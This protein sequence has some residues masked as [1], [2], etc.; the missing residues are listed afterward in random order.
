MGGGCHMT[1]VKLSHPRPLWLEYPSLRSSPIFPCDSL[2]HTAWGFIKMDKNQCL[3]PSQPSLYGS[4]WLEWLEIWATSGFSQSIC[5]KETSVSFSFYILGVS[6]LSAG[7]YSV[8]VGHQ[9][10]KSVL[11]PPD[12]EP[13]TRPWVLLSLKPWGHWKDV[14]SHGFCFK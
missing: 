6:G 4:C 11:G 14:I 8:R 10:S 2:L 7:D 3:L 9:C 5:S 1:T 12:C 13:L